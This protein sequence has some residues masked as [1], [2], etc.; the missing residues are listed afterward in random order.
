VALAFFVFWVVSGCAVFGIIIGG[1]VVDKVIEKLS[2]TSSKRSI[3]NCVSSCGMRRVEGSRIIGFSVV[4]VCVVVGWVGIIIGSSVG[5][6]SS[7]LYA[8]SSVA[9][10]GS[11]GS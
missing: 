9:C 8:S 1:T 11:C 2:S 4:L 10:S 6:A 5:K 7:M 3:V